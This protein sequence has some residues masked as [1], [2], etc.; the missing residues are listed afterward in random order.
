[1]KNIYTLLDSG[2]G[3]KLEQFGDFVIRRPD[4]EALWKKSLPE[5]EWK[6]AALTFSRTDSKGGRWITKGEILKEWQITHGSLNFLIRPTSF[7]HVGIFPEQENNWEFMAGVIGHPPAGGKKAKVLNLF[8]Y[9][10][11]ATIAAAKAGAEVTHVDASKPVIEWAKKNAEL[12]NL[13]NAPIRWLVDDVLK[14]VRREVKRGATYDGIVMDPPA[15]G[16]GPKDELWKIERD[17]VILIE[18][19]LKL[20][21]DTPLFFIVSGYASGYSAIAFANN[22]EILKQKYGGS[23]EHVELTLTESNSREFVL[24]AGVVA[25]WRK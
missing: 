10:G 14:F 20:L 19:C 24:P 8:A 25:R 12:N 6:S 21:S 13:G 9:T 18:E 2:D 15:F 7:K 4:P 11:G 17:F 3:E 23:I 5:T 16:H 22:L 1:M